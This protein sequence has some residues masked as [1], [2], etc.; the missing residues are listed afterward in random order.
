MPS[1]VADTAEAGEPE[2][3]L[4]EPPSC[5][6]RECADACAM[7][8]GAACFAIYVA[9]HDDPS[10]LVRDAALV[11]LR[12]GCILGEPRACAVTVGGRAPGRNDSRAVSTGCKPSP[13]V[14]LPNP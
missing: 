5:G 10:P 8:D 11:A 2:V 3:G 1:A 4:P 14:R 6:S 9:T 7:G 13:P 12:R